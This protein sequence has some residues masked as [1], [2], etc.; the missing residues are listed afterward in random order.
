MS[1]KFNARKPERNHEV[2][3][4]SGFHTSPKIDVE[5]VGLESSDGLDSRN[6]LETDRI[7]LTGVSELLVFSE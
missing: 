6:I 1:I 2:Y 5:D 4:T 3:L 7:L